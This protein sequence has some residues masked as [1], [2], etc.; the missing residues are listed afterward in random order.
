MVS[1]VDTQRARDLVELLD[2]IIWRFGGQGAEGY[3]CEDVSYIEYRAL[4]ILA[5]TDACT[6]QSLGQQLGF[7]KSGATRIVDRLERK[8]YV[9]RERSEDDQRICCVV[10]TNAGRELVERIIEEFAQK[11]G[12]SLERMDDGMCDVLLASLKS[13]TKTFS[14]D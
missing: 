9:R 2:E 13:F 14:S 1:E 12:A 10:L 8:F 11:T 6:M 5:K 7:T 4:R 3:C